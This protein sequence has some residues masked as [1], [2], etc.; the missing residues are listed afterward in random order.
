MAIRLSINRVSIFASFG[1]LAVIFLMSVQGHA[2][3]AGATLTGTVTDPSGAAIPNAQVSITNTATGITSNVTTNSAGF[4]ATPNLLPGPYQVTMRAAGFQTQIRNGI[5]LTV[6]EQQVLN[7]ALPLGQTSQT[8]EVSGEAAT[9]ELSSST[10]SQTVAETTV[11]ELPLN[12]RDWT[13]LANLEPGVIPSRTQPIAVATNSGRGLR[14]FGNE[15][16]VSGHRPNENNFRINGITVNDFA[17]GSP[18]SVIGGS[19]GVDAIQEFSVLTTNYSAEYGRTVGGVVNAITKSGTNA[20]HGDAYWFLRT[21]QLDARNFF[22]PATIPPFHRNNFGVSGGFPIRKDK[23][24]V[25]A[26]Y[27]GLRQDKSISFHDSVLSPAARAGNLCSIPTGV[28]PNCTPTAIKVS[29]LVTP[30]LPLYPLPNAGLT[31]N[32]DVGFFNSSGLQSA[33]ENYETV[34]VDHKISQED[35]L[36]ASY[37]NDRSSFTQPDPLKNIVIGN[38]VNRQMFSLEETHVF[39]PSLVNT[40]RIGFNRDHTDSALPLT[41]LNPLATDPSLGSIP[42]R[43]AA[44]LSVP[45]LTQMSGGLGAGSTLHNTWNSFQAYDDAFLTR[46]THS[47]KFGF[48]FEHMQ[49]NGSATK[50]MNGSF[51]FP[52]L[53]GFLLDQP[54]NVQFSLPGAYGEAGSRQSIFAGYLQDDWRVRSNLTLD[55][56]IRYEPTTLP[57]EANNRFQD[58]LNFMNGGPVPVNSP[59]AKNPTL[60]N[61]DPRVGFSWDPF[62][63]G[64]TA[65]RGGFGFFDNLPTLYVCCGNPTIGSFPFNLTIVAAGL[66]QGSFPTGVVTSVGANPAK[67]Q[68]RFIEQNPPRSYVMN[69]NF[70]IQREIAPSLTAMVG[71]VGSHSV[72]NPWTADNLNM[73][74][75]TLTSAGYLWPFPVGSGT[76]FNPNVGAIR[77]TLWGGSGSYSALEVQVTKK[78]S[79]GFQAQGAYTWG[80]CIDDSS[81]GLVSDSLANSLT[82]LL[83]VDER[84]RRGPCDYN[85]GQ[86][87][88][89]NFVWDIP[90]PKFGG[91]ATSYILGGWE[92]ASIF[93]AAAGTP[94]TVLT[95]GDP[96]GTL[97]DPNPYPDR[98]AGCNSIN[99]NYR[100]SLNYLNLSC[101]TPPVVP[102][103]FPNYATGCQPAVASV[104]AVIPNTCMNLQGNAGRNQIAGPGVTDFDFSMIKNTYFTRI[105]ESFNVQFRVEFF[106][107]LN[108]AN[109]QSP[110]DNTHIFN[111]NGTLA[112]AAGAIDSTS[113]DARQIQ[114]ALKVVW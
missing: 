13:S 84:S 86:N 76:E 43:F 52:S 46:G 78:M 11:R 14:G 20:F 57:T 112:S 101:F 103:S 92:A 79:H 59:F 70:N 104:A 77:S 18:G 73:V 102:A 68:D 74:L 33:S 47:I 39:S 72:H 80:K 58:I 53:Q 88:V 61:F 28:T 22:D 49:F 27:E 32:G 107:I 26:D 113:T 98:V 63:N 4:Y 50:S 90:K 31:G 108:H 41:A 93:T 69:W 62:R 15:V 30:F 111:Q 99:G 110:I 71:Y 5:T 75:P 24:F 7:G 19:L 95:A 109:F 34:R 96:Q 114:L 38:I 89:M 40:T 16:S 105:S 35:S 2:Q 1:V 51:T 17:N 36:A 82:T 81:S 67:A 9:V 3:V 21:R 37:F 60:T 106:N 6:G 85:V 12:G 42:G 94:F 10:I 83:W 25:F 100:S 87:F 45:S 64:K 66:A 56:G 54:T 55:L 91:A 8:I 23:T 44:T 65:V 48:A 29:P 97:G